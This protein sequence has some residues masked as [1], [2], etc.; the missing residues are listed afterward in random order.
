MLII[1][2]DKSTIAKRNVL[3]EIQDLSY[4]I[5]D[6]EGAPENSGFNTELYYLE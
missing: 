4:L 5:I 2:T 6:G 1:K 3:I